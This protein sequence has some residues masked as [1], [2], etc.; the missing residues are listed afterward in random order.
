MKKIISL[1]ALFTL[2]ACSTITSIMPL[3]H[4][5]V[6][7]D[8][9]VD[10]K[11]AIDHLDCGNKATWPDLSS[12]L[13]HIKVYSTLRNDPQAPSFDKLKEEITKAKD[14]KSLLFC[15][16]ALTI[17]QSRVEVISESWRQR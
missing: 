13:E 3:K 14:S 11:I 12:K 5:P 6:M 10:I 9:L 4:D 16:S 1:I 8:Q 15:Q 2:S 7:F 17:A